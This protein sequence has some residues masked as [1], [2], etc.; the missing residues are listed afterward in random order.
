MNWFLRRNAGTV[1]PV[2]RRKERCREEF[3]L[4][5]CISRSS[6]AHLLSSAS[7]NYCIDVSSD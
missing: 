6:T 4:L 2:L 7:D 3:Q 1:L 5:L